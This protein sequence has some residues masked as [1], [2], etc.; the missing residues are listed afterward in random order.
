MSG[1]TYNVKNAGAVGAG[2]QNIVSP[3]T[4]PP[5]PKPPKRTAWKILAGVV[6]AAGLAVS[7]YFWISPSTS[8]SPTG[9]DQNATP[10]FADS[11]GA[12]AA[13]G[14]SVKTATGPRLALVIAQTDYSGSL[15]DVKLAED[16]AGVIANALSSTGFVV[17]RVSNLTRQELAQSLDTFRASLERAGPDAVGFVYYTGHGAQH[18]Q[19]RDSYLLG[20]DARLNAA[21]DLAVYGLDMKTQ[22]DGFAATGAKVVFLVFDA[23]R[24]DVS[25]S[26]WKTNVKGIGRVEAAPDMLIA[27]STRLDDVAEEGVY[28]PILAEELVR[29]GQT[30]ETAFT[31]AQRRVANQTNR[32]QVPFT[33]P[34]LINEFCFA[35]CP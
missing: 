16:E 26:G 18:P 10:S 19:S 17:T 9:S 7:V 32:G 33:D 30:A 4:P 35:S 20:T 27:Y 8:Q 2:S 12:G 22:R 28:A 1:D 24:N 13:F 3:S 34:D 15:S 31:T 21:S 23:C 25:P 11:P 5:S 29:P 6:F 14:V